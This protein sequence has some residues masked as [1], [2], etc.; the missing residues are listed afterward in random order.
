[1]KIEQATANVQLNERA[2]N[3]HIGEVETRPEAAVT[4]SQSDHHLGHRLQVRITPNPTIRIDRCQITIPATLRAS[5]L[6]LCNGFQSWTDTRWLHPTGHLP[7]LRRIARPLM[8]YYGDYHIPWITRKKGHLHSWSWTEWHDA[9]DEITFLGSLN[10]NTAFTCFQW[11]FNQQALVIEA[12][13]RGL[14]IDQPFVALDFLVLRSTTDQVYDTWTAALQLPPL[15]AQAARG[16]TSWY[17]HYVNISEDIILDNLRAYQ[18]RP[19]EIDFFQIDDGYQTAVG[20]WLSVREQFPN[21][22]GKVASDIRDAGYTPGLWLA[23][24]VADKRSKTL[25]KHPEWLS[26]T[27]Q[28]RPI[29]AGYNPLWGGWY[30]ALDTEHPSWRD[31]TQGVFETVTKDWGFGLLKLDFLFAAC[32]YP[33]R[34]Q[35]RAQ[36]MRSALEFIHGAAGGA[37]LLGCGTPLASGFGLFDYCRIGADI[38]LSWEHQL[39][40]WFWHRERVSTLV[41]LRTTLAR[42]PLA[43]RVWRNDPDVY[44]L[45]ED[46]IQLSRDERALVQRVNTLAGELLF[47]SDNVGTY[48]DWQLAEE[49]WQREWFEITTQAITP[50]NESVT[51]IRTANGSFRVELGSARGS[52]TKL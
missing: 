32:L 33:T 6:L 3:I 35:T 22:M 27:P 44:L 17:Q 2:V 30:Y 18:A 26:K 31:Y 7:K 25:A 11:Q 52:I 49:A 19:D 46:N 43:G 4:F 34:T 20:D 28:N 45:R 16:W 1:M 39:L 24:C 47:T 38:H 29:K 14:E 21:G 8:G 50:T 10:E 37:Y 51:E 5:D 15:R 48:G 42:W 13:C 40:R 36:R 23:P 41:A 9:S 12:D